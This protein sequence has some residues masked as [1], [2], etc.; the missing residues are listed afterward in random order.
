KGLE[1]ALRSDENSDPAPSLAV[2]LARAGRGRD[3]WGRWERGLARAVLDETAG[4]AARPLTHAE[5]TSEVDL[6]GR[7]Q[8]LDGGIGRLAGRQRLTQDDEKR[9]D[10]PRREAGELRRQLLDLQQALE[11]KYG[12]LAGQPVSLDA[13]RAALPPDA[14]L[15][16]WVDTEF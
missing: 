13:A 10:D 16:G 4:R 2:V 8:A 1:A 9:L 5:R 3:A 7:G 15:V 6:L 12:P 14:A 11:Q